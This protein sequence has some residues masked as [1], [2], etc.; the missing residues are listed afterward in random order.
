MKFPLYGLGVLTLF[1]VLGTGGVFLQQKAAGERA[2]AM[3]LK[4]LRPIKGESTYVEDID[5]KGW[6]RFDIEAVVSQ[7][8]G[9]AEG[10][11]YKVEKVGEDWRILEAVHTWVACGQKGGNR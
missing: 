7:G 1:L 8:G 11:S 5:W 9:T 10:Y 6:N 4:D 2:G 3:A